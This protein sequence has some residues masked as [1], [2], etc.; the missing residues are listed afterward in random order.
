[1]SDLLDNQE[2]AKVVVDLATDEKNLLPGGGTRRKSAIEE[3]LALVEGENS[4]I[5]DVNNNNEQKVV[6]EALTT[7]TDKFIKIKVNI[8]NDQH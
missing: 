7:D 3:I 2:N 5:T 8:N 4:K 6:T 1:M